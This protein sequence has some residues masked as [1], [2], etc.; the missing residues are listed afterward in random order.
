[1]NDE[2]RLAFAH[3][4]E[5]AKASSISTQ[6]DRISLRDHIVEVEIGA[7]QLERGVTQRVSF[8]IVVEV[9]PIEQPILDDVDRILSY[10]RL[11][12]AIEIELG[13]E[14]LN[15]LETLAQRIADRIL[16]EPQAIRVFVRIEK[17]DRGPGVL[18]VEIVRGGRGYASSAEP[19][20][21]HPNIVFIS[22][23][24]LEGQN[25]AKLLSQLHAQ[26]AAVVL[27]VEAAKGLGAYADDVIAQAHIDL[28][29]VEQNAWMI[30]SHCN[31]SDVVA[32]RTE[33]DW[34]IKNNRLAIWAPTKMVMNATDRFESYV[35][36]ELASWL[37][38]ELDAK[39]CTLIGAGT[40]DNG[41]HLQSINDFDISALCR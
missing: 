9:Q 1:M 30:A 20:A 13:A 3:P 41:H 26:N 36:A 10:D 38:R 2:T 23:S 6:Y 14:R 19:E 33:L 24:A 37:G 32:T 28:L 5:R 29:A 7:F 34:A 16:L 35:P 18:G 21:A 22:N 27:C 17:L 39:S 40:G 11:T 31:H 8:N 15:L 25:I 12:E 4:L